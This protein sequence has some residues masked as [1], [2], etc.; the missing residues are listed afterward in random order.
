VRALGAFADDQTRETIR[1]YLDSADH[2]VRLA[3]VESITD[4]D[5]ADE[6]DLLTRRQAVETDE[7]VLAAI[8]NAVNELARSA[9]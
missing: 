5:I 7:D 2:M 3:A 1:Q 9:E 8:Q 6:M 4:W